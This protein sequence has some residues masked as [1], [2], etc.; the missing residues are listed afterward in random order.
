MGRCKEVFHCNRPTCPFKKKE[1][2]A[3]QAVPI[4]KNFDSW[5]ELCGGT[6]PAGGEAEP[7]KSRAEQ[8]QR[9]RFGNPDGRVRRREREGHLAAGIGTEAP[10]V[11]RV[12]QWRRSRQ[13]PRSV[14]ENIAGDFAGEGDLGQIEAERAVAPE[15]RHRDGTDGI[16]EVVERERASHAT[17]DSGKVAR[18]E[19]D[20]CGIVDD[21]VVVR[22][23][24]GGAGAAEPDASG[25]RGGVGVARDDTN[26]TI[27]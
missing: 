11:R 23:E 17:G 3:K 26:R 12:I 7:N 24:I 22:G 10:G 16:V 13:R 5:S 19:R 20:D 21:I 2:P 9:R 6:T 25:D 8:T 14:R 18:C 15:R 1:R 27:G 4:V